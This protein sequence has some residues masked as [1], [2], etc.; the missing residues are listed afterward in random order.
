[1]VGLDDE[2][3]AVEVVAQLFDAE[4]DRAGLLLVGYPAGGLLGELVRDDGD[5]GF[6]EEAIG[7]GLAQDQEAAAADERGICM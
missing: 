7:Q 3:L 1:M 5:D 2:G 4:E 6:L